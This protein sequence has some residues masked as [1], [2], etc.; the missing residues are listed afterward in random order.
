MVTRSTVSVSFSDKSGFDNINKTYH[1]LYE[2]GKHSLYWNTGLGFREDWCLNAAGNHGF[3]RYARNFYIGF[4]TPSEASAIPAGTAGSLVGMSCGCVDPHPGFSQFSN[5][6]TIQQGGT[7]NDYKVHVEVNDKDLGRLRPYGLPEWTSELDYILTGCSGLCPDSIDGL[8][9]NRYHC[10]V[11]AYTGA[12]F[13]GYFVNGSIVKSLPRNADVDAVAVFSTSV[14]VAYEPNGAEGERMNVS[15]RFSPG[16]SPDD[17]L[18]ECTFSRHGYAFDGWEYEGKVFQAGTPLQDVY[19]HS[20]VSPGGTMTMKATWRR[21]NYTARIVN[22]NTDAGSVS[23]L[24]DDGSIAA[25]EIGG[26]AF[27]DADDDGAVYTVSF[28]ASSDLYE[29]LGIDGNLRYMFTMNAGDDIEK[30]FLWRAKE[31]YSLSVAEGVTAS[32]SPEPD[33]D[34]KWIEGRVVL[35]SVT[36]PAGHY[37]SSYSIRDVDT[38]SVIRTDKAPADGVVMATMNAN[39]SFG[40][41]FKPMSYSLSASVDETSAGAGSASVTVDGQPPAEKTEYGKTAVFEAVPGQGYSFVGWFDGEELVSSEATYE[42]TVDGDLSFSAR[43]ACVVSFSFD[44][45]HNAEGERP[46]ED[47]VLLVDGSP[48]SGEVPLELGKSHAYEVVPGSWFFCNFIVDGEVAPMERTG[49]IV[50]SG[51]A[52]FSVKVTSA[53]IVNRLRVFTYGKVGENELVSDYSVIP[54]NV[55]NPAIT[56]EVEPSRTQGGLQSVQ[57][58]YEFRY[59]G[60]RRVHVHAA[61]TCGGKPFGFF[62]TRGVETWNVFSRSQDISILLNEDMEICACYGSPSEVKV[63]VDYASGCDRTMGEIFIDGTQG[64][65]EKQIMQLDVAKLTVR[66]GNGYVFRGWYRTR[67]VFGDPYVK[68]NDADL[69]VIGETALFAYFEKD[70]HAVY[71]WEGS[72]ENKMM[73]W[74][75][76]LYAFPRPLN[77]SAA[78]VDSTGYRPLQEISVEMFSAPDTK[79]TATM[80]IANMTSQ[81]PR[82]LPAVRPERYMQVCVRNTDEVDMVAVDT[83]M[84][85]LLS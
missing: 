65:A 25:E 51:P 31:L 55:Q 40:A 21:T 71:R 1:P 62:A 7:F 72:S 75:S 60:T 50:P 30:T 2:F 47:S 13:E 83:S 66:N 19:A 33:K 81:S 24:H 82:R 43:F 74:R 10:L 14:V 23:I 22:G 15:V 42:R 48:V 52:S 56:S 84:G 67:D 76:R 45:V 46:P 79:P 54:P 16:Y 8:Q 68:G 29:P 20:K 34:G 59:T 38:G 64:P 63:S 85:G 9:V 28:R 69:P 80:R 3:N 11:N 32:V 53:E 41:T 39:I 78:R 6:F 4:G 58:Y 70:T 5:L 36:P 12:K 17:K 73:E 77:P 61:D 27:L 44:Y 57:M 37:F 26:Y 35:I 18:H 49:E